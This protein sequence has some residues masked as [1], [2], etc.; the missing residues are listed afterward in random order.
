[1]QES[2]HTVVRVMRGAVGRKVARN[3]RAEEEREWQGAVAV[4]VQK[5]YRGYRDRAHVGK[6]NDI[7]GDADMHFRKTRCAGLVG[8]GGD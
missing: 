2:L 7:L 1:M 3:L 5:I 4:Q 8:W 6:V